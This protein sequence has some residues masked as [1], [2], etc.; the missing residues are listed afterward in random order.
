MSARADAAEMPSY[1]TRNKRCVPEYA[2]RPS[3]ARSV[4]YKRFE[5]PVGEVASVITVS[6]SHSPAAVPSPSPDPE[7]SL[8]ECGSDAPPSSG[9]VPGPLEELPYVYSAVVDDETEAAAESLQSSVP[10]GSTADDPPN[11]AD[12]TV[13][14]FASRINLAA[15]WVNLATYWVKSTTNTVVLTIFISIALFAGALTLPILRTLDVLAFALVLMAVFLRY[16]LRRDSDDHALPAQRR[17][18]T[19]FGESALP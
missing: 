5:R 17:D 13:T 16:G 19:L 12:D 2:G 18:L 10:S 6:L 9:D 11:A 3:R 14:G 4:E 15:Y 8:L 1:P 7:S